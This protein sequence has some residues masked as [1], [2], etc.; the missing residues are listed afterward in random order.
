ME[1][2]ANG[3]FPADCNIAQPGAVQLHAAE[4]DNSSREIGAVKNKSMTA[5]SRTGCLQPSLHIG[6]IASK[7]HFQSTK[8]K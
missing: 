2:G 8:K 6:Y 5:G 4:E 1:I 7:L 3:E